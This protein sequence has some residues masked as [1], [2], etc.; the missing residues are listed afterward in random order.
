MPHQVWLPRPSIS[1]LY[2]EVSSF[3][4]KQKI[5]ILKPRL[6]IDKQKSIHLQ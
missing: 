5:T 4:F 1:A 6:L 2:G 3:F